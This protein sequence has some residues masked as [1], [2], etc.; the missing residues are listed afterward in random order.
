M[1]TRDRLDLIRI[2]VQPKLQIKYKRKEGLTQ[3]RKHGDGTECPYF[4]LSAPRFCMR[5]ERRVDACGGSRSS[6]LAAPEARLRRAF[7]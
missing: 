1:N 3:T 5:F 2:E 6:T 4:E 7:A